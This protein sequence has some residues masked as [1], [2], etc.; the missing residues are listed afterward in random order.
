MGKFEFV[1]LSTLRAVQ[2]ISGCTPRVVASIKPT[3]TAQREVM[4][5]KVLGLPREEKPTSAARGN[6]AS[7]PGL[8]NTSA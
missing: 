8:P 5:G 6:R 2:L 7:S 1:R 3:T 4:E